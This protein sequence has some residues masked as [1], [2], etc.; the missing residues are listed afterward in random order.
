M[1]YNLK[2][3]TTNLYSTS[4]TNYKKLTTNNVTQIYKKAKKA[5]EITM[6]N[7][8]K[9]AREIATQLNI[10]HK[11]KAIV[12]QPGFISIKDHKPNFKTSSIESIN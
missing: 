9:E 11:I 5:P 12:E 10:D 2:S 4:F 8:D 7:I 6:N 1:R 3:E